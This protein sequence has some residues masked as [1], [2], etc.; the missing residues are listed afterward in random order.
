M[1]SKRLAG[2]SGDSGV[3]WERQAGETARAYQA[4]LCYLECRS[5]KMAAQ[6]T[7]HP[8]SRVYHW[9][10]KHRWQE[11]AISYDTHTFEQQRQ[12]ATRLLHTAV[13]EAL[14]RL[15]HLLQ[16]PELPPQLQLKA[17]EVI[18]RH[19]WLREDLSSS[20]QEP[21]QDSFTQ[22]VLRIQE[23]AMEAL[24]TQAASKEVE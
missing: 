21:V 18:L 10:H 1:A 20:K 5:H 3:A 17:C 7:G 2:D 22:N 19:S 11:R 14:Q 13:P 9:S 12:Q 4:F 23:M 6:L 15:L 16:Q 8:L 24:R